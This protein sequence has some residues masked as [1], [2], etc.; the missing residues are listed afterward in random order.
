[1][2]DIELIE[3]LL[4]HPEGKDLDFKSTAIR[5]DT[6]YHKAKFI[7]NIICMANTP[8]D[9][10][11]FIVNGVIY[12]PDGTKIL[13]GIA[14]HPDDNILQQ[15]VASRLNTSPQFQ[16]RPVAYKGL[17]F[18]ITEIFPFKGGPFIPQFDF[19]HM[20]NRGALYYRQSSST[21]I[22]TSSAEIREIINWMEKKDH[23]KTPKYSNLK[24][25]DIGG[26]IFD[27]P[28]YFP[29]ISSLRTQYRPVQYLKIL[30]KSNYP[31]FLISAYDIANAKEEKPL[32]LDLLK[33]SLEKQKVLLDSGYYE[34]SSKNGT[35]WQE[36]NYLD[37][38][39]TCDFSYAFSFDKRENEVKS[40]DDVAKQVIESWKRDVEESKKDNIIPIVHSNKVAD[41]PKIISKIVKAINPVMIAAPERELGDG[42]ISTART[43][44]EIRK[45]LHEIQS[46]CP[47]HLL[48]TGNPISILIYT[49]CGANSYDGLEWCQMILNYNTG[50]LHH[51]KHYD[52]MEF[53]SDWSGHPGIKRELAALMHNIEFYITWMT[54][55]HKA[56]SRNEI[57]DMLENY[58]PLTWDKNGKVV[59]PLNLLEKAIPELFQNQTKE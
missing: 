33:E 57:I 25:I 42:I 15:L 31:W 18:G 20:V 40:Q 41:F 26:G 11:A 13:V 2:E 1:M 27:F 4:K 36:K 14:E 35:K 53:Q 45:E 9:G 7:R 23:N 19:E 24:F 44:F 3:N 50:L 8:R 17:S 43:I 21:K 55:L 34:S 48:G 59:N 30:L 32:L 52:F 38:V 12:N 46:S 58:L 47:I 54:Q 28:C 22:A 39:K 10:S 37:I 16:Y 49:A 6:D 56:I 51:M 29:S 5:I